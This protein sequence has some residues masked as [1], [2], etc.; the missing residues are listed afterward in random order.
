M[1]PTDLNARP[2]PQTECT[3]SNITFG[4]RSI[5]SSRRSWVSDNC[6]IAPA[7]CCSIG[8]AISPVGAFSFWL[9]SSR[10]DSQ[11]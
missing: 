1:K 8:R 11:I 7:E 2:Q 9:Q 3:K 4:A 5:L 10:E 6:W